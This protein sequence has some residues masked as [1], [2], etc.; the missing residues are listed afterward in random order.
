MVGLVAC[1]S[2]F[3]DSQMADDLAEESL[4]DEVCK[5]INQVQDTLIEAD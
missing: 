3:V 4:V 5:F 1:F 2:R